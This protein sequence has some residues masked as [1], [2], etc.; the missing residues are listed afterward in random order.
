MA[1]RSP[2]NT[3][4]VEA[5]AKAQKAADLRIAGM[6]WI[7]IAK[8]VGYAT[9]SGAR[10]AVNRMF[11]ADAQKSF[12]QMHPV[13]AER[14][15]ALWRKAWSRVNTSITFDEWD[16]AM[17]QA[18]S[19]LNYSARIHG[20]MDGPKITIDLNANQSLTSLREEFNQL[21]TPSVIDQD[22]EQSALPGGQ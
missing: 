4:T 2:R 12:E 3:R 21:R 1:T 5:R 17:R 9:E 13:L 20:L 18:L 19:V 11:E 14:A 6:T 22:A 10:L 15:E 7:K 16:K 8:E